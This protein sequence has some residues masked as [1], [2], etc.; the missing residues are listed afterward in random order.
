M[1]LIL[2][3]LTTQSRLSTT[4][5]KKYLKTLLEKDGSA[6]IFSSSPTMFSPLFKSILIFDKC[7]I[8]SYAHAFNFDWS[9]ISSV[10]K[11]L[12]HNDAFDALEKKSPS[13]KFNPFL[14]I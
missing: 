14:H 3:L 2:K 5:R 7:F 4:L 9:K 6:G 10:G 13:E 11:E 1:N 8:L 12:N